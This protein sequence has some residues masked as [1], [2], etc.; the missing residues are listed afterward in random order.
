LNSESVCEIEGAVMRRYAKTASEGKLVALVAMW[1]STKRV[2]C[3][4]REVEVEV[5]VEVQRRR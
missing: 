2:A 5:Q 1:G 3:T 4:S